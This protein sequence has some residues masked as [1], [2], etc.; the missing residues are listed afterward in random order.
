M[1]LVGLR[2][3]KQVK[4]MKQKIASIITDDEFEKIELVLN[5][6]NIFSALAIQRKELRHSNFIGYIL[7]PNQSHGL[8]DLVLKKFLRDIFQDSKNNLRDIFDADILDLSKAE[9]RREWRNLDILVIL[10]DDVVVV[11]NKVDSIDHS[12]QLARYKIIAEAA[13][14][15]KKIH[16]VYLTPYGNDPQDLKAKLHYVNYS[17]KSISIII[18]SILKLYKNSIS[19]KIFYYL[20]DYLSTIKRGVL[21]EDNLNELAIKVYNAHKEAFDFIIENRPDPANELYPYF[22]E[23]L[24]ECGYIIASKYKGYIR[25]TTTELDKHL[26]KS[27]NYWIGKELFLFEIDFYW[28]DKFAIFNAVISPGETTIQDKLKE[29]LN[30]SKNY[31]KPTGKKWQVVSKEKKEFIASDMVNEEQE[32]IK[33]RVNEIIESIKPIVEEFS[34]LICKDLAKL[35]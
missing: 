25:F 12:N 20:S 5:E 28:S 3:N 26:E 31:R 11:E 8:K 33:G 1:C 15:G 18:E 34:L 22:E 27:G 17:Y 6:P 30:K 10:D 23:K 9:I 19:E 29:V 21:M 7:D 2:I 35:T 32:T 14:K 13:F 16:Y 4:N 24:K